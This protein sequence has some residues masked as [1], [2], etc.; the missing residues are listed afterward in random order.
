MG[1]AELYIT[2]ERQECTATRVGTLVLWK[3]QNFFLGLYNFDSL[4]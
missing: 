2:G 3:S 1:A 4:G